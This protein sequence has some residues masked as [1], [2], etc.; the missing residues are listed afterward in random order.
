MEV[1]KLSY[2]FF[3]ASLFC[4]SCVKAEDIIVVEKNQPKAVIV[5]A[6]DEGEQLKNAAKLLQKYVRQSTGATIKITDGGN[7][8]LS[9]I[10]IGETE[11]VKKK[12]FDFSNVH[13][14]GFILQSFDDNFVIFGKT[15][16]GT[17]YGVYEFLERF[18]G[19]RWL[20]PS[21]LGTDIIQLND[22]RIPH[23]KDVCTPAFLSRKLSPIDIALQNILGQWGRRNRL[24]Q[25]VEVNHNLINLFDVKEFGKSHADFFPLIDGKRYIPKNDKDFSWQ[26]NFTASGIVDFSADRIIQYLK[27]NKNKKTYS[28]SINDDKVN[29]DQ[30]TTSKRLRTLKKNSIGLI[31][32]SDEYFLWA[33]E[34]AEKV[35]KEISDVKFGALAY[36]NV[37][38][39][40]NK[41]IGV[42]PNII[43]FLT[44]E[45]SRWNDPVYREKDIR[46]TK[47]WTS[48]ANNNIG[49][50]D[51][52]YGYNYLTPRVWP[53]SMQEYLQ[54]AKENGVNYYVAEYYP[55]WGEGPKAWVLS[56]LLW[57]PNQDVDQLLNEWYVRFAGEK[58]A[59]KLKEYYDIWEKFWTSD[60]FQSK[61]YNNKRYYQQFLTVGYLED[62]PTEYIEQST[63][64]IYE[65]YDYADTP[66]RKKR[67][68]ELLKMWDFYKTAIEYYKS[69]PNIKDFKSMKS[70]K[71]LIDKLNKLN[72]DPLHKGSVAYIFK[73]LNK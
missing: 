48:V 34:V 11:F 68:M 41:D 5:I 6:K 17:E 7:S 53:H 37:F 28:L 20:M 45:R 27:K 9:K 15:D 54:W 31:D 47:S 58:A 38:D 30:S 52:V 4:M 14:D 23:I 46:L 3:I 73:Y 56:K 50:Y 25:N 44:N 55:N 19:V 10:H 67:V 43:P 60:I 59:P 64:L 40:P 42:H 57:D 49:W 65:A 29:L 1:K 24:K 62:V 72:N 51:Y 2:L 63:K 39:P 66:L 32:I 36:T 22:I 12:N 16:W 69:N 18:V 33:N 35:L 8:N 71:A 21:D 70:S 61:W 26:P 13:N